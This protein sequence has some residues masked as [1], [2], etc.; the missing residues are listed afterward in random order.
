MAGKI[1]TQGFFLRCQPLA[2]RPFRNIG[3]NRFAVPAGDWQRPEHDDLAVGSGF[4]HSLGPIH[5]FLQARQELRPGRPN[6][7]KGSAFNQTFDHALVDFAQVHLKAKVTQRRELLLLLSSRKNR[8]NGGEAYVLDRCQPETNPFPSNRE[9]RVAFIYIRG[10][11]FDFLLPAFRQMPQ[12]LIG[13]PHFAA[14]QRSHKFHGI[15]GL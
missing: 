2:F 8:L 6:A 7:I 3:K 12:D 14:Q 9:I 10:E 13:I 11:H 15:M 1:K 4:L 5:R